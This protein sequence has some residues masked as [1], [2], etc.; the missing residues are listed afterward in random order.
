MDEDELETHELDTMKIKRDR[1]GRLEYTPGNTYDDGEVN[2]VLI[3]D[4]HRYNIFSYLT[5]KEN[6]QI[7]EIHIYVH[8]VNP[9]GVGQYTP[10]TYT[11]PTITPNP[12]YPFK[13]PNV[14]WCAN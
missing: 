5:K 8:Q 13:D 4:D 2:I 1:Q 14:V 6:K 10:P 3:L 12:N 7:V 9:N 11:P